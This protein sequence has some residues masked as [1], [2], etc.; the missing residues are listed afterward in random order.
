MDNVNEK[1][2]LIHGLADAFAQEDGQ[3]KEKG[4]SRFN[5]ATGTLIASNTY[6]NH[7]LSHIDE[8]DCFTKGKVYTCSQIE[9]DFTKIISDSGK[10]IQVNI[11]DPDFTFKINP[12]KSGKHNQDNREL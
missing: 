3:K 8:P 10:V 5:K 12:R 6:I 1:D 9:N 11:N 7:A 2:T 4:T